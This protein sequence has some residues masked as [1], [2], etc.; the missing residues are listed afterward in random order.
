MAISYDLINGNTLRG[1]AGD[2]LVHIQTFVTNGSSAPDGI[3][4][5]LPDLVVA[6]EDT[7]EFSLTFSAGTEPAACW[8]FPVVVGDNAGIHAK[9]SYADGVITVLVYDEDDVSGIQAVADTTDVAIQV[10]IFYKRVA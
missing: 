1:S 8:A 3:D 10:L 2:L 6:R 4:P 5:D 9:A 7:G